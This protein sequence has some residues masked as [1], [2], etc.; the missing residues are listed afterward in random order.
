MNLRELKE[1]VYR[2]RKITA[3]GWIVIASFILLYM[4]LKHQANSRRERGR[5]EATAQTLLATPTNRPP[6]RA[7]QPIPSFPESPLPPIQ[8]PISPLKPV[9]PV[10]PS[11]QFNQ[12]SFG[13]LGASGKILSDDFLPKG[14]ILYATL[15]S[16]IVSNNQV[17]PATATIIHPA[18][19]AH[20]VRI[21]VGTQLTGKIAPGN[22]RGRVFVVWDTLIFYEEGRQGWELPI[23]G[24]GM[25]YEENP[26]SG[27]WFINGAGLKG[28]IF[29]DS[30][31][32]AFK[33][34]ALKAM[35]DFSKTLQTY[36]TTQNNA[37]TPGSV[38]TTTSTTPEATLE[39][40]GLA[41]AQG[42]I[43]V[44]ASR[45]AATL[46][47]QNSYVLVPTA[48]LCAIFLDEPIDLTQAGP[49]R[50]IQAGNR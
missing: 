29:D 44:I 11:R 15:T 5:T 3:L 2:D 28:F 24:V 31:S 4:A 13:N 21:P 43:D 36:I 25:T 14:T 47:Q 1:K 19:F 18:I 45:Y 27:R 16:D 50:S 33:L 34:A 41:A 10:P 9:L 32:T 30:T 17:S 42:F 12:P 6:A 49:G 46:Q 37:V 22:L 20:K 7:L 40:S 8:T 48:R 35:Q 38:V 26:H 23:K 39:N